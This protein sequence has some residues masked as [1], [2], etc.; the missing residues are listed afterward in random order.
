MTK[1]SGKTKLPAQAVIRHLDYVIDSSFRFSS[2]TPPGIRYRG[3]ALAKFCLLTRGFP[4][5]VRLACLLLGTW[6]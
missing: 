2:L 6:T 3:K 5:L 4:L 1:E